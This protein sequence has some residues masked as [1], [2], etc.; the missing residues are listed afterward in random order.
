M[1]NGAQ[2]EY[3]YSVAKAFTFATIL[4]GIIGMTVGVIL[5]FQLAFP[6]LSNLAG[7][8]GTF[9]RLRPIHTNGVAFGFTL[10]GVFAGWYYIGQRVLKVS[11]KESPF[12]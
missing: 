4:F 10:S 9:S 6:E 8:Y 11:L 5:A 7:E 12:L 2:I 1:Q 3:D